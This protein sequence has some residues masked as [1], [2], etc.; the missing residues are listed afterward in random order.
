[1]VVVKL[2]LIVTCPACSALILAPLVWGPLPVIVCIAFAIGQPLAAVAFYRLIKRAVIREV[3][4][5]LQ[6]TDQQAHR[7]SP[8]RHRFP[9]MP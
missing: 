6:A 4:R 7:G 8:D 5:R 1:M 3:E 9:A 2:L